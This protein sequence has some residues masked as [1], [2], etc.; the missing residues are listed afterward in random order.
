MFRLFLCVIVTLAAIS[1]S[2]Q[3][4]AFTYQG[5]LT[6]A[7]A[8]ATG[9]YDFYFLLYPTL[10][11]GT[12]IDPYGTVILENVQVTN[13]T[14]TVDLDFGSATPF[15]SN[16]ARYLEVNIRPGASTG[17][18]TILNPRQAII[19]SPYSIKALSATSA[20][21]AV[22][23]DFLSSVCV[24]CIPNS[25]IVSIDGSKITGSISNAINFN[26]SGDGTAGGTLSGNTVDSATQY[27]L[28]G[29]RILGIGD[30]STFAG[31]FAGSGGSGNSFFGTSAG[32]VNSTGSGNSFFGTFAG[33]NANA[34]DNSFFGS[35]AG[36][37]T[38]GGTRNSFFGR[39]AGFSNVSGTNNTIIGSTANVGSGNLNFATAI[40]AGSVVSASN[41]IVLGRNA[42]QDT[43][44][45]P[46]SLS[47]NT[48][49]TAGTISNTTIGTA[50]AASGRFT[51]LAVTQS[52]PVI[53]AGNGDIT[54]T[55][56]FV[57][58]SAVNGDVILDTINGGTA[59]GQM[60]I[61]IGPSSNRVI[62]VDFV[63]L[64]MS[65]PN[66]DVAGSS[67]SLNSGDTLTLIWNGTHWL[68]TS[69]SVN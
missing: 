31:R 54:V 47:V 22:S 23:A 6:N 38:T 32:G 36:Q 41:T 15:T 40:G 10:S 57:Q 55:T 45:V 5:K 67:I 11:G 29:A 16:T 58:L 33:T 60:L 19:S 25:Q 21:T 44:Q 66:I 46:G 28:G 34:D 12:P 64:P 13:G 3:T 65:S 4:T 9:Q 63:E 53:P 68:E 48:I 18:Y 8:S 26:I 37:N 52:G 30:N 17:A 42:G 62:V 51:S 14:F 43:V 49:L 61:L 56:S 69:R 39:S 27:N 50:T 1:V 59:V 2:A 7:G 20:E 35:S 24:P